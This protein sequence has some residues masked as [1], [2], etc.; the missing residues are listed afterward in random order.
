MGRWSLLA[1][2]GVVVA[3]GAPST[4]VVQLPQVASAT[5]SSTVVSPPWRARWES[6]RRT[7]GPVRISGA[8]VAQSPQV[9][10]DGHEA[11]VT[12][13]TMPTGVRLVAVD[14]GAREVWHESLTGRGGAIAWNASSRAGLV[15]TSDAIGWLGP[16]GRPNGTPMSPPQATN[17]Q[18]NRAA[19]A[20]EQGFV[21]VSGIGSRASSTV[22]PPLSYAIVTSSPGAVDWKEIDPN[23]DRGLALGATATTG[24]ATWIVSPGHRSG[25]TLYPVEGLPGRSGA[26]TGLALSKRAAIDLAPL[27]DVRVVAVGEAGKD[28][29]VIILDN[30]TYDLAAA[31]VHDG[32]V[33]ARQRLGAS[34]HRSASAQWLRVGEAL[35]VGADRI[36]DS[37]GVALARLD[38]DSPNALGT[39]LSIGERDSQQLRV[40][41]TGQGFVAVWN[42]ADDGAPVMKMT[43]GQTMH[44]LSTMLAVYDCSGG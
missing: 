33:G 11:L 12:F 20:V 23:G 29:V 1:M 14:P 7:A 19:F 30:G 3:C 2:A 37:P 8:D 27:G 21:L 24:S 10:W 13:E 6:C 28:P 25:G 17:I 15:M 35:V 39:A 18:F 42:I 34:S 26:A 4:P 41:A 40:S 44:A 31:R 16:D 38:L 5:A 22:M 43:G 32:R 36:G 9:V